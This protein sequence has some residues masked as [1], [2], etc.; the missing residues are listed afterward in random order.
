MTHQ[1]IHMC[2]HSKFEKRDSQNHEQHILA[3]STCL[4]SC[5]GHSFAS[6][7]RTQPLG[8]PSQGTNPS[9]FLGFES[10]PKG[11]QNQVKFSVWLVSWSWIHILKSQRLIFLANTLAETYKANKNMC[12]VNKKRNSTSGKTLRAHCLH[13]SAKRFIC[14]VPDSQNV[15]GG[16]LKVQTKNNVSCCILSTMPM[17]LVPACGLIHLY[18]LRSTPKSKHVDTD[19]D[20]LVFVASFEPGTQEEHW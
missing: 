4:N 2:D 14:C 17:L 15:E 6:S 18:S 5:N 9:Y 20:W 10:I 11:H 19:H 7:C 16:E 3:D 12:D 13:G 8:D 1:L